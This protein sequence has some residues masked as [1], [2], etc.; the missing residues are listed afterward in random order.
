[1]NLEK[2]KT[3]VM[4]K[5]HPCK[6]SNEIQILRLGVDV[7]AKCLGCKSNLTISRENL[8]KKLRKI[9]E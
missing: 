7:K 2:D 3:I 5:Q 8:E 9:K 1:M 6:L 4:K